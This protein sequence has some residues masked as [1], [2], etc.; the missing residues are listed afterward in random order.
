MPYDPSEALAQIENWDLGAT[1]G[2][3]EFSVISRELSRI[4]DDYAS[5]ERENCRFYFNW[6]F[7]ELDSRILNR[8]NSLNYGGLTISKERY[9]ELSSS[10]SP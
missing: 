1:I 5:D 9:L 3:E 6:Y 2:Y 8:W 4:G 7:D 10:I